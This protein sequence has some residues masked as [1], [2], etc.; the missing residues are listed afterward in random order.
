MSRIGILGG[1]FDPIHNAHLGLG[2]QAYRQFGLDEIWFMPSGQPPHKTDHRVTEGVH[3]SAMVKLA[4]SEIP[5]F[6]YSGFELERRGN[7]YTAQTL[8]LLRTAYPQH[9]FYFIVGADSL[10]QIEHWFHPELVME[11]TELLVAVRPWHE[12]QHKSLEQQIRY[13]EAKYGARIHQIHFH[14][15]DISSEEIRQAVARGEDISS[16]VPAAVADYISKHGL[17]RYMVACQTAGLTKNTAK[18]VRS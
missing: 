2:E 18:G 9:T 13:L 1:T 5:C 14:E 17:Y 15:T 8:S 6:T 7:T 12:E 3:R 16:Y 10:Y 11:Q 4:I